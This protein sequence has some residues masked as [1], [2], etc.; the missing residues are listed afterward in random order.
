MNSE[1]TRRSG[2]EDGF[3]LIE[4]VVAIA[5][6]TIVMGAV[7]GLLAVG[8]SDSFTTKQR[9]EM[10]QNARI[11]MDTIGRD[12]INAGVG[13]PRDGA[14]I[15]DNRL[16][17]FGLPNDADNDFDRI[18]PVLAGDNVHANTLNP[19]P[20]TKTDQVTFI[21][22]DDTFN[23]GEPVDVINI[24]GA[25]Q[26]R[27]GSS[28]DAKKI[29]A[30]GDLYIVWGS[31]S[32]LVMATQ[33]PNGSNNAVDCASNDPL[34]INRPGNGPLKS[35]GNGQ[36]TLYKVAMVTYYVTT[37][38]TLMRRVWGKPSQL[39]GDGVTVS[40]NSQG[41]LDSPLAFNVEDLQ[42]RYVLAPDGDVVSSPTTDERSS[43]RQVQL[44]LTVRSPQ[45]DRVSDEPFRTTLTSTFSTR[46]LV[47]SK[48]LGGGGA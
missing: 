7:Y 27:L 5:L 48:Q 44:S 11:A 46:N 10:M 13:F 31:T 39:A 4:L 47:Y 42:I 19:T 41:W 30:E 35:M 23:D 2:A 9:V 45:S 6:F 29:C 28:V 1:R 22:Q 26:L 38:G 24:N 33:V 21:F 20:N 14:A 16:S 8:T 3:S 12:A 32:A 15:P 17:V 36:K 25:Q 18:S 43:I 40:N 34:D 37:D